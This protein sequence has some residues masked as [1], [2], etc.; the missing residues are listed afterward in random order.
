MGRLYSG[1]AIGLFLTTAATLC[2]VCF[3]GLSTVVWRGS[4]GAWALDEVM[5]REMRIRTYR[6]GNRR[7]KASAVILLHAER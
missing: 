5:G 2:R 6:V 3:S 1:V 4:T 7:M